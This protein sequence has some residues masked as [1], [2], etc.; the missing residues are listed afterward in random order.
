[1]ATARCRR[2]STI[3]DESAD[4]DSDDFPK[5]SPSRANVLAALAIA[6]DETNLDLSGYYVQHLDRRDSIAPHGSAG[7]SDHTVARLLTS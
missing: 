5:P 2:L 6:D 7:R 3:R 1:L 4:Q